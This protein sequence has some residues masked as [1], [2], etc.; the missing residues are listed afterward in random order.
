[1]R[2]ILLILSVLLSVSTMAQDVILKQ[3]GDE[4]QCKLIEVGTENIK[5]KKWT[6]LNGP[7][8]VDERD[9]VFMIKYEN[10]E[11]DVF[12]VRTVAH[13]I[14]TNAPTTGMTLP[15][16]MYDKKSISG[17]SAGG[18]KMSLDDAKSIMG[19][20]WNEFE[21]FNKQRQKGKSLL[22]SGIIC[23]TISIPLS[24]GAIVD[25]D[26]PYYM[27]SVGLRMGSSA[28]LATGIVK[29]AKAQ[30]NCKRLVKQHD[31]SAVGFNPEFDFGIG[32]NA[33]TF[34]MNF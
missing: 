16:L 10:G 34:R 17:L 20:D 23:R 3:N 12:G 5:Y 25:G 9:D 2:N 13:Q 24:V 31:S 18:V 30:R 33:M 7:I 8:F 4:I 28:L 22:I 15:D 27:T 11:K 26:I 21:G 6:N 32:V 29:M 14:E 1:M 19:T